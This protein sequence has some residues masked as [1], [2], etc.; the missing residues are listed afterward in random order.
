[1]ILP[2]PSSYLMKATRLACTDATFRAGCCLKKDPFW[3]SGDPKI[4]ARTSLKPQTAAQ[5]AR[6]EIHWTLIARIEAQSHR[7][8]CFPSNASSGS[9]SMTGTPSTIIMMGLVLLRCECL[10]GEAQPLLDF[11]TF[12]T[13]SPEPRGPSCP[14][15]HRGTSLLNPSG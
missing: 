2:T 4:W 15:K 8:G 6:E 7:H 3:G 10:N 5:K 13:S 9:C 12:T 14:S 1:M 11:L